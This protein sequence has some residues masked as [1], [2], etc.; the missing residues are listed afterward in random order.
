[1]GLP[2]DI[3]DVMN[4]ATDI[5]TARMMPVSVIVLEDETA[6]DDIRQLVRSL[7]ETEADNALVNFVTYG[8]Q[9]P[10]VP[11]GTDLAV[12]VAGF[13]EQTGAIAKQSRRVGVPAL[14]V[15]TLPDIVMS[16]AKAARTPL[17]AADV[18]SPL[19][20]EPLFANDDV[21]Q[22]DIVPA[23]LVATGEEP[24][25]LDGAREDQLC[26]R[27]GRWIVDT[28]KD[29]R[30]AFALCFPFVR[31]P[32][33]L[34]C[35]NA[36]S[37]QNAGIGAVMFI[38]G[39]DMPIM[40][41]NQAKMLL[42]IAAAYGQKMGPERI[43]EL[44][45]VVGG[46]FALRAVA[47]QALS[48]VPIGGWIIKGGIGYMGTQAM[49]R[50]AIV[51]FEQTVGEGHA[52]QDALDAAKAEAER[53]GDLLAD[54]SSPGEAISRLAGSYGARIAASAR[55]AVKNAI[56]V[57]KNT[58]PTVKEAVDNIA[59]AAGVDPSEVAKKAAKSAWD[60]YRSKKA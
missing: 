16:L 19:A 1:M 49:G 9:V 48:V 42:Q 56:P 15:T 41:A 60:A 38:P 3:K 53:V 7:F 54:A 30:L 23:S 47:R 13:S 17:L 43:K 14:T 45:G 36:T 55:R 6:P 24:Y 11:A 12:L 37:V 51:Y 39:A 46:A 58:V 22:E 52:V 20:E 21:D 2:I 57:V 29:K 25:E 33:A 44:A 4:A 40:T 18:A 32:L 28:F 31:R 10:T 26:S 35:V 8:K 5:D 27:M 59:E 34:E 50:A